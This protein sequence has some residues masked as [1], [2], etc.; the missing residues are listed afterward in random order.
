M[1]GAEVNAPCIHSPLALPLGNSSLSTR[2]ARV[3]F[4]GAIAG[5]VEPLPCLA[6]P[7]RTTPDRAVPNRAWPGHE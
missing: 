2:R 1:G 5:Y 6:V 7:S 3:K 4:G